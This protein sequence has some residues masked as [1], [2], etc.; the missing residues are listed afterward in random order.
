[1]RDTFSLLGSAKCE[2]MSVLDLKDVFHSLHLPEK[3]QKYCGIL[4]YFGSASYLYQRMPMGLNVSP[5]IWQMYINTILNSLQN[6]KYC[7]VIIDDLLLFTPSKKAH[8]DKLE[9]LLKALRKNGLKI[10][11]K[12]CQLFR[13]ELQYMGNTIFIIKERR[14]CVKPLHSRLE[15]IEKVK[16]PTTAKQC[17]R[18]AG[19]L[20]FVSIF[21][22]ELQRLLKPIYDLTRKGRQFV[23][24]KE[25]QDAFD[26]I[27]RRLQ[28]PPVLHMPDKVGRFQL[29]SDTSKYATG[30]ALYQIQNGKP[31]LIA[32]SSKRLP[33]A[34]HNY[35]ITEL[36]MHGLAINIASFAHLLRKVNFD[37]VVDHLAITQIMM[38]KV[39]LVTNRIKRLLEVLSAYSF[40]LYYI[41]GK[42]MILSDFLSRQDP[43][44]EDTK[45]IIPISFNMKLVLQ[46]SI[47]M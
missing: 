21:C 6:R 35:S 27:K 31:K 3:S 5:P 18:F 38:S 13:T 29:Y 32:Y 11:P 26:E 16:A 28:I 41:K 20:N 10:S 43:G 15:A 25:Q 47:I 17:K 36:E 9:D 33:E 37:A 30:G 42:D 1:M 39:E 12:K 14:V 44:D 46:I 24:G 4:P 8:M 2:V 34:A 23:W 40:N 22:P 45:E 7:E 19:I